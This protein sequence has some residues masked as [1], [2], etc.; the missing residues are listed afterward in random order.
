MAAQR[1]A[2]KIMITT[3]HLFP[4][5]MVFTISAAYSDYPYLSQF[6]QFAFYFRQLRYQFVTAI[7]PEVQKWSFISL[8]QIYYPLT[9]QFQKPYSAAH[10]FQFSVRT[11]PIESLTYLLRQLSA[12]YLLIFC[13]HFL[14]LLYFFSR[15]FVPAYYHAVNLIFR[16]PR[17]PVK[18]VGHGKLRTAGMTDRQIEF[19]HRHP[20][21]FQS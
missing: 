4:F 5:M 2:A 13:Y 18:N 7:L 6:R 9:M 8:R 17:S 3:H 21:R 15:D 10:L 1:T 11:A 16:Y 12:G 14:Y 19:I 20:L